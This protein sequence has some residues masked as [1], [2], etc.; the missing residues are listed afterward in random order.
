MWWHLPAIVVLTYAETFV[1][2]QEVMA[3]GLAMRTPKA[4]AYLL[5][6]RALRT[7]GW[8]VLLVLLTW[9][10]GLLVYRVDGWLGLP[11][12]FTAGV[13]C[14]HSIYWRKQRSWARKRAMER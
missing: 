2:V 5:R 7:A 6:K 14:I 4:K 3:L 12:A 9:L 13:A 11:E 10:G 8:T 1:A